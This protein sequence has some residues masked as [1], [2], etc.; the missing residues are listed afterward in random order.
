MLEDRAD[1]MQSE[2]SLFFLNSFTYYLPLTHSLTD[3][4]TH[5]QLTMQAVLGKLIEDMVTDNSNNVRVV[6]E[7]ER[8]ANFILQ[9]KP[10]SKKRNKRSTEKQEKEEAALRSVSE[11]MSIASVSCTYC[12]CFCACMS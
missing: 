4:C 9:Q 1:M 6:P 11:T 8:Q 3:A 12:F 2:C 5:L 7:A 10:T